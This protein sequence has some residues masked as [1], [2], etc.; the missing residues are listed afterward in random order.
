[1]IELLNGKRLE[2]VVA[3]PARTIRYQEEHK[4]ITVG[5]ETFSVV[6]APLKDGKYYL[7]TSPLVD[8]NMTGCEGTEP[9]LK[10]AA[11]YAIA[12]MYHEIDKRDNFNAQ[13]SGD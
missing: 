13:Y 6:I 12:D 4:A 8:L 11:A 2:D 7:A 10:S 3:D 9:N 1:M 5:D